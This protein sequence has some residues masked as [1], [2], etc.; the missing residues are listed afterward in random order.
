MGMT[1]SVARLKASRTVPQ[2][3]WWKGADLEALWEQVK[4]HGGL[5]EVRVELHLGLD[6]DGRPDAWFKVVP[7][8]ETRQDGNGPINYSHTCPPDCG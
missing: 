2:Y 3:Y 4:E 8:A 6:A 5:D 1:E 7:L